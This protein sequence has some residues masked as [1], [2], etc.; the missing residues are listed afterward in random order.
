MILKAVAFDVDG[1]LYPYGR[2]V[3]HALAF[4]VGN[5][6]Y[7][8]A[9]Y[10]VR[11]AI[12]N[13]RPVADFREYQAEM[14]ARETSMSSAEALDWIESRI[15]ERWLGA[16]RHIRPYRYVSEIFQSVRGLGLK[17]GVMSDFP[18]D[19]KLEYLGLGEYP[20]VAMCSEESGYL[21]PNIEPFELLAS[22]LGEDPGTILY[23]GDSYAY[24]VLGAQAAGYR[25][26]HITRR[27]RASSV[28]DLQFSSYL[29]LQKYL[30]ETAGTERGEG[31][32]EHRGEDRGGSESN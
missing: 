25:T 15:Y 3:L 16:F 22:R 19:R 5:L 30:T 14:L 21:K 24:D 23:V 13:A 20:H 7:A 4:G 11:R 18:V 29:V 28:A 31:R 9:F 2:L 12:R 6:R 10:R 32:G 27:P 1:T 8:P 17:C 26:A